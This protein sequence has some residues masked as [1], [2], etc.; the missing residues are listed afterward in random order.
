MFSELSTKAF[1]V[2]ISVESQ[3]FGFTCRFFRSLLCV[4]GKAWSQQMHQ[5]EEKMCKHTGCCWLSCTE[6]NCVLSYCTFVAADSREFL[7]LSLCFGYMLSLLRKFNYL[8]IRAGCEPPENSIATFS[9]RVLMFQ[10]SHLDYAI[11]IAKICRIA[12]LGY[13]KAY[14]YG[15]WIKWR[16][17]IE[18]SLFF[19]I[20]T[21]LVLSSYCI[22]LRKLT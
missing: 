1:V 15:L 11:C 22:Q 14:W 3:V 4:N 17:G 21:V 16:R 20:P 9:L 12:C 8:N 10:E 13:R 18:T 6:L 7:Y 2:L 19:F 5:T